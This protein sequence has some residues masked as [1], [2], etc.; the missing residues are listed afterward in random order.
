MKS[1]PT[2]LLS[3]V[4]GLL[5]LGAA[6][7]WLTARLVPLDLATIG[8]LVAGGLVALGGVGIVHALTTARRRK[9]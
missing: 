6:G 4:F 3:L 8:W 7:W 2:D 9:D 1:H 5:F